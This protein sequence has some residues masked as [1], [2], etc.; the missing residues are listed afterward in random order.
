[1]AACQL[2]HFWLTHRFRR[3]ASSHIDRGVSVNGAVVRRPGYVDQYQSTVGT[4]LPAVAACQLTHFWLTHRFRRQASSHIDRG[5]SVNGALVRWPGYVDHYQSTVGAGLP[6]MAACQLTHFWLTDRF[7]RQASSHIDRGV[8]VKGAVVRRPGYVDQYQSTVG[9]GLP[10]MAACQLTHFWLTDRF[11]RQASSHIDRGVSV[12]GAVV[13]WP[14]YVDQ[15][16]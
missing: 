13:R 2:A 10:A 4:G 9:A 3:Q 11:R 5:V 12:N 1:M 16:R 15:H 7:R 8:L 6:A 14:G